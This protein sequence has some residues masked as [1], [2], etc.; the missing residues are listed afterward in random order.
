MLIAVCSVKG[1]PGV[2]TLG[3]GLAALWPEEGAVLLECDPEGG[4]LA[5]RFGHH[6]EPGLTSLA[7]ASRPG[8]GPVSFDDHTQS[9][10]VGARVVLAPPGDAAAAAVQTL[11]YS[12]AEVLRRTADVRAVI[13]DLGRL[14]RGSAGVRLAAAA[15]HVL[16]VAGGHLADAL[17]VQARLEW[18]RPELSG[19]LWLVRAGDDGYGAAELSRALGVPVLGESP[20]SRLVG[21]A[22]AGRL[23]VPNWRRLRLARAMR[24]MA[25]TLTTAQPASIL[26]DAAVDRLVPVEVRS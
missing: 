6:P 22:L 10:S 17:Q 24:D 12:G 25:I 14:T 13:V 5:A 11:V 1:A 20:P 7:A 16:V 3:L 15:D 2:T 9:V 4:D 18:L 21:G 19:R 26:P 23:Q 8:S